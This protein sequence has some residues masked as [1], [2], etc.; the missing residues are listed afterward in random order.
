VPGYAPQSKYQ[1][2]GSVA[3]PSATNYYRL[4]SAPAAAGQTDVMTVSV[5]A[6]DDETLSPQV[7]VLNGNMNPV[8]ATV[9]TNAEGVLIIQVANASP[10][11][12]YYLKVGAAQRPNQSNTGA[13]FLDVTFG[14]PAAPAA[15]TFASSTL[16]S[17]APQK[18]N[19]LTVTQ[20]AVFAF[21]LSAN[22][23]GSTAAAEVQMQIFDDDGHLVF[24]LIAYAGQQAST[25]AVYLQSGTYTV[26]FTAVPQTAGQL[27]PLYFTLSGLV[28]SDPQGP[29]P[30]DSTSSTSTSPTY[31]SG[32]STSSSY[33]WSSST[34]TT[35]TSPTYTYQ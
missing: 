34:S 19:T 24:T 35:T 31:D 13:Y 16:T 4:Q 18:T 8:S 23:G 26:R 30:V 10:N 28:L 3:S 20:N 25:G 6:Q 33:T 7:Q 12:T 27:P 9:L 2:A 32:S 22:T 29:Q 15:Q 21:T 11:A 14:E 1:T 5:M 17:S